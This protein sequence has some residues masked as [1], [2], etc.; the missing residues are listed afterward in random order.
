[1]KQPDYVSIYRGQE[2]L[3]FRVKMANRFFSRLRGFMFYSEWPGFDGLL[4]YP[5][6]SIHMFWMQFPLD[7]LYLDR[8]GR[9]IH[10]IAHIRPNQTGPSIQGSSYVLEIPTGK[11]RALGV[12]V[13]QIL[14]W[15]QEKLSV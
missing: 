3:F 1:M 13:G 6:R 14:R 2:Q 5:C 10:V 15:E 4:L 9:V 8:E 7:V 11:A 12:A